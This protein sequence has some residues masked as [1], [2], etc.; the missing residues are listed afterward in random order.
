[1]AAWSVLL[2]HRTIDMLE[3][4]TDTCTIPKS[5]LFITCNKS[6]HGKLVQKTQQREL[7]N[8]GTIMLQQDIHKNVKLTDLNIKQS[9]RGSYFSLSESLHT[10]IHKSKDLTKSCFGCLKPHP[11]VV[12][13]GN[14][15]DQDMVTTSVEYSSSVPY[16][17]V[18]W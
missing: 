10:K 12:V 6:D 4:G 7:R 5:P 9:R 17:R 14:S 3:H 16:A 1:M 2:W 11:R 13:N 8:P 18:G 15:A